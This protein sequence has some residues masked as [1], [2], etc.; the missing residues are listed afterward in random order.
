MTVKRRM[1]ALLG[2]LL[3]L[4][5][6]SAKAEYY[7]MER[8]SG[9]SGY[10]S[11]LYETVTASDYLVAP[12]FGF[13]RFSFTQGSTFG[14]T[15][16]GCET[17]TYNAATCTSLVVLSASD[18]DIEVTTGKPWIVIDVTTAETASFV[19]YISFRGHITSAGSG[20]SG[21]GGGSGGGAL[22]DFE[23][24]ACNGGT[25]TIPA[26]TGVYSVDGCEAADTIKIADV[27]TLDPTATLLMTVIN[28]SGFDL[29]VDPEILGNTATNE[30]DTYDLLAGATF[31]V[32]QNGDSEVHVIGTGTGGGLDGVSDIATTGTITGR[33]AIELAALGDSETPTGASGAPF[34]VSESTVLG[35]FLNIA[36]EGTTYKFV[37]LP[38]I[39][40]VTPLGQHFCIKNAAAGQVEIVPGSGDRF[41]LGTTNLNV[42]QHMQTTAASGHQNV[43]M[44]F[45]SR[46]LGGTPTWVSRFSDTTLWEGV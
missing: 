37:Q 13:M 28:D 23:N 35:G 30:G 1:I 40:T 20:G 15:V 18:A 44:C 41:R 43:E 26:T 29:V 38:V 10:R 19:S 7:S 39:D 2:L 3:L 32:I 22:D 5:A 14:A 45:F 17:G 4:L 42:D 33:V 31:S 25:V 11:V 9:D 21:S 16:Y 34:I 6:T 24:Y 8:M 46:N 27:G 36:S 12:A